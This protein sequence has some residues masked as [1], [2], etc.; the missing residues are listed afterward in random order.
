M[1]WL[2]GFRRSLAVL[3][4]RDR[5][6]RELEEEIQSHLEMQSA[7]NRESGMGEA[8]AKNAARRQF[9]NATLLEET[10]REAW[11]WG[12]LKQLWQDVRYGCR[13]IR[14]S[15]AFTTAVVVTL[16]LGIGMNVAIFSFVDRLLLRPLPFP[17]S[18]RL[19][20]LFI[21]LERG[22]MGFS[23]PDYLAYRDRNEVFSSLAAYTDADDAH[24]RFGDAIESLPV[25]VVTANYFPTLGV[26]PILGRNFAPE[27]DAVAGRNP[28]VI[29]SY[30]LWLRRFAG[31]HAV[32]GRHVSLNDVPFTIIGVAPRNF[33]GIQLDRAGR[34]ELWVPGC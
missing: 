29:I 20:S 10:S 17:D 28:V 33:A 25:D 16:A 32:I 24:V 19:A 26:A 6:D 22:Y 21:S 12:A 7:E 18:H 31:D 13:G 15:P 8:E 4:H 27:E 34:P 14:R 3:F 5:F 11:G 23:Y 9:G 30:K 2:P 1:A